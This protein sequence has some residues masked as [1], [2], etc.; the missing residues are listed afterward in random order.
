MPGRQPQYR[1]SVSPAEW[2]IILSRLDTGETFAC[3][4]QN[5]QISETTLRRIEKEARVAL[6]AQGR[7]AHRHEKIP[8][9]EWP[10]IVQQRKQGVS[11]RTIANGYGVSDATIR[12]ILRLAHEKKDGESNS[13]SD[14]GELERQR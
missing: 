6:N 14:F 5:Y 12:R 1:G 2:P 3:I 7:P 4:A 9:S 10:A 8:F 13:A 11:F